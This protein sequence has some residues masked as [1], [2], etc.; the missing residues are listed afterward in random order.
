MFY[1]IKFMIDIKYIVIL[2]ILFIFI[3][4]CFILISYLIYKLLNINID[5]NNILFYEYSKKSQSILNKYGDYKLTKIHLIKQ[6]FSNLFTFLL[7]IFTFY[8]Y[9]KIINHLNIYPYHTS[10]VFEIVLPNNNTK[11]I[12]LEKNNAINICENIIINKN[13]EMKTIC[14]KNI[15]LN[16]ILNKTQSRIGV[17]KYFNWNI[18]DNNCKIFIKEILKT[19][20]KYTKIHKNFIDNK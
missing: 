1:N 5:T 20:R 7:N 12:L 9:N 8:N 19:I 13:K 4:T 6:P 3:I 2:L 16:E 10:L 18:Y 15:T 17:K 14:V 11:F